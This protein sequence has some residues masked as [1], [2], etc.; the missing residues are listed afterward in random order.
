MFGGRPFKTHANRGRRDMAQGHVGL[1]AIILMANPPGKERI[2]DSRTIAKSFHA[3]ES[4]PTRLSRE[5]TSP[6]RRRGRESTIPTP[7]FCGGRLLES[8]HLR[9][10][11]CESNNFAIVLYGIA[12]RQQNPLLLMV[13]ETIGGSCHAGAPTLVS[14][15]WKTQATLTVFPLPLY[16]SFMPANE[17]N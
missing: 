16:H 6:S 17:A 3:V 4:A 5:R 14:S 13:G 10:R 1:V 7:R 11:R 8:C 2:R 9:G 15:R 12:L